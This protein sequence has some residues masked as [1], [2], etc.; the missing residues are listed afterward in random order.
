MKNKSYC[1]FLVAALIFAFNFSVYAQSGVNTS[2]GI[3]FQGVIKTPS[4][5]FPTISGTS[6]LVKILSPDDCV[7]REESFSGVNVSNG[8]LN[9]V[10]GRG[11]P[12]SNNPTPAR[13]LNA[14]MN[15]SVNL[16]GL[17]CLSPDGSVNSVKT[18]YDPQPGDVRKL[19]ISMQ[20]DQDNVVA[21]FNMRAVAYAVN[22]ESLNGKNESN[23]IN[24]NS[25]DGLTQANAES[26]F[27]R[28]TQLNNILNGS[29]TGNVIGNVSGTASNVTGV[30]ALSNGG[31]GASNPAGARAALEL[32]AL[33]LIDLPSPVDTSKFLRGD[34]TWA[35][36]VGGVSSV[37]GRGGDVVVTTADLADFNTA[38]DARATGVVNSLKGQANG[39]A[40][41]DAGGKI[42]STQLALT[43]A[44]IPNIDA[45]KINSGTLTVPVNSTSVNAGVGQ[46][47]QLKVNDGAGKVMTMTRQAGGADYTIQ[48]PATVG[49]AGAVLQTDA[50]GVLSWAAIP[51]AP[52]QSVAGRT[53]AVTLAKED[54]SGL[55]TAAG[56]NAGTSANNL[57]QLDVGAKIP[58]SLLPN[59]VLTTSTS[60]GGDLNGTYPNPT[61][62]SGAITSGK[63][64]DGAVSALSKVVTAP[65]SAG[66]NRLLATDTGTGTT[67]KD[68]YCTTIG[69]YLKWTGTTGFGCAAISSADIADATS[70]NSA[71]MVVKRDP[72]GNFSAGT[73]TANL[74]GN[75]TGN[76][77][78]KV[79]GSLQAAVTSKAANYNILD[80]DGIITANASTGN[81]NFTLPSA[82]GMTGRQ[83]TIKKVDSSSNSV[84]LSTS[85]SQ[86][87]DGSA[88][89]QLTSQWQYLTVTSDGANWIITNSTGANAIAS[90][91]FS[92]SDVTNAVTSSVIT[93][94]TVTTTGSGTLTVSVSGSGSPQVSINGGSWVT[95]GP[96]TAGQTLAVRMT[97]SSSQ[98]TAQTA[99]ITAGSYSANWTVTTGSILY[100]FTSHT[101]TN[102]GQTGRNGP[103]LSQCQ[104]S[105]SGA[106]WASNSSYY[107]MTTQGIQEWI[108]P[109]TGTYRI[110][111]VGARGGATS[112][113][114]VNSAFGA[115]MQGDFSLTQGTKLYI[116]VGQRGAWGG[117]SA[118]SPGGGGTFVVSGSISSPTPL[119][120]AGGGAGNGSSAPDTL[121]GAGGG[122]IVTNDGG[123]PFSGSSTGTTGSASTS[124][125]G[126]NGSGGASSWGATTSGG[127]G[128]GGL[129]G[130][131]GAK[132]SNGGNPGISFVNGGLGGLSRDGGSAGGFGGGGGNWENSGAGGAG[133]GY[134]GG[135]AYNNSDS[136]GSGGGGSYN[137]GTNASNQDGWS[138]RYSSGIQMSNG[139]HGYVTITKQ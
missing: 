71:N 89:A 126:T 59:S 110:V 5:Q 106:S 128:G 86:T 70:A 3:S 109:S 55:G 105:Y 120:V 99:T 103:T 95:S 12:T 2:K 46:F 81:L 136:G 77:T 90:V 122:G 73:V 54:I 84:T 113:G 24:V 58:A 22:A 96:I 6:V 112:G 65:G 38:S 104:S 82:V 26:I 121:A 115:K 14:V 98:S 67:I 43:S 92:F 62:A 66:T 72:S 64:A 41:L 7:L 75:V 114:D 56:L 91:Q 21:D 35:S 134:S 15:N 10:L 87:I 17:L 13:D 50:T 4:G 29:F 80:S 40:T 130:D 85:S 78:G 133:G 125:G 132:A 139:G 101:F 19:R 45:A 39:L 76:L 74:T 63:I 28:Y 30:V 48:W 116:L 83:Y 49:T 32:K 44:D 8:Y 11:T 9:L 36:V 23:F 137:S 138:L 100:A 129:L 127:G 118:S 60:A 79:V 111:A 1:T 93:S 47:T 94:S 107:N 37:A 33:A 135:G 27:Q 97:S 117:G 18:T 124:A 123:D 16:S 31:T 88:T 68:F 131:G 57:V 61:V 119:I 34:G 108:V 25:V 20:I 42:P 51:S 53:G 69:H 102:C 52:V